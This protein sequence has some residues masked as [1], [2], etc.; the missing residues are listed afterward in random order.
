MYHYFLNKSKLVWSDLYPNGKM[1]EYGSALNVHY[2]TIKITCEVTAFYISLRDLARHIE[3][4]LLFC[5]R[6][7]FKQLFKV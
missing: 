1:R 7:Q 4:P 6:I 3:I 2:P 5:S